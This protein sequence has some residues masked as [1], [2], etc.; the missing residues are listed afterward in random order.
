MKGVV[1]AGTGSGCGKTT[2]SLGLMAALAGRGLRVAPFKVGPDFIDPGH[3]RQAAGRAGRNLDGWMLPRAA[4]ERTFRRSAGAADVAVVEGVMGLFDG[5]DGRSE[6]GST[7]E[8]AKW[9]GL[10]V[11]LVVDARSMARSAAAL[12]QGFE[13]FDPG[14]RFAG[15]AFNRMGSER[16]LRYLREALADTVRM[17][18]LGGFDRDEA[19]SVPERHLGLVTAEDHPLDARRLARLAAMVEAGLDVDGLLSTLPQIAADLETPAPQ[20]PASAPAR[21]GVARDR[22]FCFYYEDNLERLERCGA[23]LVPFS[24]LADRELPPDLDGLYFGGG[25]PELSA[26]ALAGNASMRAGVRARVGGRHADLRRV[27]GVHVPLRRAGRPLRS[28]RADGRLLP[29]RDPHAAAPE[30]ARL[31]RGA[32]HPRHA[33]RAGRHRP[34]R[35]RVPLLRDGVPSR[36]GRQRLRDHGARRLGPRRAGVPRPPHAGELRPPA[37]RQRARRGGRVRRRLP[38]LPAGKEVP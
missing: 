23:R 33:P 30:V 4:N 36:A 17:P 19:V 22:A 8:M 24:P 18:C 29:V 10:P 26:A 12:V 34:A 38:G 14:L 1:V 20:P 11:L 15:V 9:L 2:I 27:R 28:A 21:I 3:H 25:Y 32:A 7:A 16:H 6:S 5:Y 13:N 35:P 37:L 31:P